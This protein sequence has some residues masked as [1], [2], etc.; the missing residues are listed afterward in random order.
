M[1]ALAAESGLL[2]KTGGL[3]LLTIYWPCRVTCESDGNLRVAP[4][5]LTG[6]DGVG[7]TLEL[8]TAAAQVLLLKHVETV[9]REGLFIPPSDM[10]DPA[11][12]VNGSVTRV[13]IS[14]SC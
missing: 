14:T 7:A 1:T 3:T 6:C 4:L 13:E 9:Q 11:E 8:A 12:L 10:L 5:Q 2:R